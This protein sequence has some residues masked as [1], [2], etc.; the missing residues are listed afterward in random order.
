M[1]KNQSQPGS[2]LKDWLPVIGL[3]LA[4]FVFNTS[5]FVPIGLLTDIATDLQITEARAGLLITVYA[6]VVAIASLP[7]MLLA[8]RMEYRKLLLLVV[9]VFIASHVLSALS[10]GYMTLMIS[11]IGVACSHAIFW[12]IASPLAVRVAPQG[13][14]ATALSMIVSGTAIAMIVGLP[15]GRIIGLY[16]GWRATFFCI[17]L[18]AFAIFLMLAGT[19]PK[20]PSRNTISLQKLPTLFQ[21]RALTGVYLLTVFAVTAH[22]TGYSYIEP[23]LAQVAHLNENTITLLLTS[24]GIA[25]IIGSIFFSRHYDQHPNT[26]IRIAIFGITAFLFLLQLS[27]ASS[28][29]ITALCILWGISITAYNLVF[30]AEIIRLAPESTAIAMSIYSGIY[31]VGIGAGAL[32]GGSVCTSLSIADI[33]YVGGGIALV[34]SLYCLFR[35]LPLLKRTTL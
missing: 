22:Y 9:A 1:E 6:W 8:S 20:V 7:L 10:T 16:M 11:R 24:F 32:V 3:T 23:F 34:A 35:L 2:L 18:V 14:G 5:E 29:T 21:N 19:F 15:L 4:G 12:S 31:N 25:G 28:Y 33:G 30:Q 26:F 17:A 27:A 13:H